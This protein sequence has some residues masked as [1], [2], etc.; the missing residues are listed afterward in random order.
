MTSTDFRPAELSRPSG[1]DSGSYGT[2]P[3]HFHS[4]TG[5][6][7]KGRKPSEALRRAA[8]SLL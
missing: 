5:R 8:K 4:E 3:R 6:Y 1:R 7:G 2:N